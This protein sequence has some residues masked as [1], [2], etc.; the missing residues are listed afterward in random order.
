MV[1]QGGDITLYYN[2]LSQPSRSVK[3]IMNMGNINHSTVNI[4]IMKGEQRGEAFLKINP[5]GT[6]PYMVEGDWR[7]GESTAILKYL[8]ETRSSIPSTL[9]PADLKERAY[10][11]QLLEWCQCHLRTALLAP[12]RIKIRAMIEEK[13]PD[14]DVLAF[15]ET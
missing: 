1:E 8:C 11:D 4:D 13:A 9:W 15:V 12:L 14:S 10:V 3:T 5:R 6:I 2:V 7:L